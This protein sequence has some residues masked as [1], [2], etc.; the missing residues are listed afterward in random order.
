MKFILQH[1]KT[2][3]DA[4]ASFIPQQHLQMFHPWDFN[5]CQEGLKQLP[6]PQ[7]LSK[8]GEENKK[9]IFVGCAKNNRK[10]KKNMW[11]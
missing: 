5:N 8:G 10:A 4:L 7:S 9:I 6:R 11:L 1:E 2:S 3:N